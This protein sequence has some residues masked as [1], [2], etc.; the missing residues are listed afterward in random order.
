[1]SV[2]NAE[3]LS[4]HEQ[5]AILCHMAEEVKYA[6]SVRPVTIDQNAARK[7]LALAMG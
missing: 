6:A 4:E 2:K 3:D 1:M 7:P 5:E